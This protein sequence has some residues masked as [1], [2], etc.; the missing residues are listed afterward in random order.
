MRRKIIAAVFCFFLA[1]VLCLPDPVHAQGQAIDGVVEGVVRSADGAPVP[2]AA[3]RARNRL[4]GLERS[5]VTN[6][7]GQ[8]VIPLL[9]PGTYTVSAEASGFAALARTGVEVAA[10]Q[11]VTV[12]LVLSPATVQTVVEVV[13]E[14]P[15]VEVGRT[16]ASNTQPE[17]LVRNVPIIGRSV[18][19]F[20][21]LQPGVN[22][23]PLSTGGSGTGTSTTI[24]GGLGLRQI[25]VDGVSNQLQ[26]GAR[27]IVIS[28]EAIQEFQTVTN[29]SAEFGRVAGGLQNAF[30]RS[31][32]NDMHGSLF[33]FARHRALSAR[34][35]LLA[36]DAPKPDFSRYHL[37]G[38]LGGPL[39][40]DRAFYFLTYERWMQDLPQ[41]LTISPDNAALIGIPASSIGARIA[42]FRAHTT[43]ARADWLLNSANRIFVRHNFYFDRESPIGSGLNAFETLQRWDE[44]P[45][46]LTMQWVSSARQGLLNELRF[47]WASRTISRGIEADKFAPNINIQG[48][49]SFNGNQN[50]EGW[51]R[52]RGVQ[53]IN[54][55]TW[56]SG[57]H[58]FK[59]GVDLLPVSF[60]ERLTNINGQFVF[61][62][63]PAVPGV[64]PAVSPLQQYLNT[65]AGVVDPATGQPFS[66]SR[67]TQSIGREFHQSDVVQQGYFIQ[68]DFRP[69]DRLKINAGLRYEYFRRPKGLLNPDLPQ[70]GVIPQD[71]SNW[72]P[73]LGISYDPWGDG[74]TVLRAGG[75]LYYNVTVAQT[76][77][78]FLRGNGVEV[79]NLNVTPTSPGAP[80]FT[81]SRVPPP[82]GFARPVSDVRIFAPVFH[83]ITVYNFFFTLERE[84][85]RDLGFNLT[86]QGT[87]GRH[88]PWSRIENLAST[89]RLL[90]DGRE[91]FSTANRPDL[92]FGNI[93][94]AESSG[95]Q[96]YNGLIAALNR[97]FSR[98]LSLQASYHLS[99]SYGK[100]FV[101]DF[102]GF[103]IFRTPHNARDL[104]M[105]WGTG[106]FDMRHRFILL[107]VWEP[108]RGRLSGPA[109]AL[110]G[111]WQ[112]STR[113]IA[114]TGLPFTATTGQDNN[115]DTVFNDRPAGQPVNSF[116]LPRYD[117]FDLRL[118]RIFRT[119]EDGRLEFIAESFNALNRT[120][121]TNV[122]RVWGP[123][124]A[125]NATFQTPVTAENQRQ[126]QLA[127]RYS[128]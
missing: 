46:N 8:Y 69:S 5:A 63:L 52:E 110:L 100:A 57:R 80:A 23:R 104:S 128:F 90:T 94:V 19:D 30:T 93:L 15:V 10:G 33:A 21:T 127:V 11:V 117:I 25:N 34:P 24:Y 125:P 61:G 87:R 26:G 95:T 77:N 116:R 16:V 123:N 12:P 96:N 120:N 111:G 97:R 91:V 47:L 6:E 73:R 119:S 74:K 35:K 66:Y 92:R 71:R 109:A 56:I 101:D 14:I 88:L 43:T 31:G 44:E 68:D 113:V 48:V 70:T 27:N 64:R 114:Q 83:D 107:G 67:F 49:A 37:G 122:N 17:V 7:A 54:N 59:A 1:A 50:G 55:T 65:L 62:G 81:R 121:V 86:Y 58:T 51:S 84:L 2:G 89:G 105:D 29:F 98:G 76:F 78:N 13:A 82:S 3:V 112:I 38:T 124:P 53:I 36:P 45:Q 72:A 75:G 115:G 39:R 4:T 102:T 9:P 60:R 20:Y 99:R 42:T 79:I 22:A 106:E 28:Q 32:S 85:V 108:G 118:S 41:I 18:Q 40:R 103:G 126:F